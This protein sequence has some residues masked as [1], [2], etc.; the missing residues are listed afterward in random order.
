MKKAFRIFPVFSLIFFFFSTSSLYADSVVLRSVPPAA[1][2]Q[3]RIELAFVLDTTGSM[4]GLI[5]GAKK[6]IWSIANRVIDSHPDADIRMGLVGYRDLGDEYVTRKF[7]LTTDVQTLYAHLLAFEAEGGGDAP[8]SVN[9]ALDVAVTQLGWSPPKTPGVSRILFLVGDAPPHMDYNQD[10][11]YPEVIGDAVQ[12]GITV[13]TVQ[14][15]TAA[16]TQKVW[17]EMARLGAGQYLSIP[18]DGGRTTIIETPYDT[19]IRI[20][21]KDLNLT[22]IPYGTSVRQESVKAKA[23][24]YEAVAPS[25]AADMSSYVSKTGRGRSAVTGSGDLVADV[26][27]GKTTLSQV[28]KTDLPENLQKMSESERAAYLE[29]Q[30]AK[31]AEVSKALAEKISQRDAYIQEKMAE[32]PTDKDLQDSFDRSVSK[33]LLKQIPSEK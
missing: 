32:M 25:T 30:K 4:T 1:S 33:T 6:K 22:I 17:Q 16:Q 5:D 26:E 29:T 3:K 8:E 21:Q 31:R 20:L 15:G 18:Q 13:N 9:E 23:K 14:A 10:R 28:A 11:K 24:M 2:P 19:E 27:K 7:P 12:R